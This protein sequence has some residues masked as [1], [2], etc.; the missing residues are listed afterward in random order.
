M[1]RA[2]GATWAQPGGREAMRSLRRPA[3]PEGWSILVGVLL[4]RGPDWS[5]WGVL[6]AD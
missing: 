3:C 4:E 1:V 5:G 6:G 2:K